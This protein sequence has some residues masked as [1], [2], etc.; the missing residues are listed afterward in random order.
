MRNLYVAFRNALVYVFVI[1]LF[2]TSFLLREVTNAN[3]VGTALIYGIIIMLTP[4]ILKFFK[5]P[6]N[7][8]S[9]IMLNLLLS[10][11][12]FFA[13]IYI[14]GVFEVVTGRSV[15]LIINAVLIAD[16][17]MALVFLSISTTLVSTVMDI[18]SDSR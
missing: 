13:G 17:T 11:L 3:L 12:Y 2:G 9:T 14:F 16:R 6:V 8:G 5:L 7:S 15:D 1:T 10:F 18:L 4:N